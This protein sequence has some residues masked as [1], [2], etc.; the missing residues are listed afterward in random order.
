MAAS[1]A[2][3]YGFNLLAI[4][5]TASASNLDVDG[6]GV[7]DALTDGVLIMRYLFDPNGS[8]TTGGAIWRESDKD[9]ARPDQILSG[10]SLDDA[11]R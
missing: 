11:R 6:N 2:V 8:W 7:C 10:L 4:T 9:H 3:G 1:N 5:V